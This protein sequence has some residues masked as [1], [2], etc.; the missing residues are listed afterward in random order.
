M[1]T[2]SELFDLKSN[3]TLKNK[4]AVACI[5]ASE[6]IRTESAGTTNHA[7]RLA[8]AKAV[9]ANP[10]V[11]SERMMWA[12]LAQNSAATVSQITNATDATIQTAVNNAV[13]VF[14]V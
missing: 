1:A 3:D 6:A 7:E 14:A 8:W 11:E 5:I 9:F 2:Y 13:N 10:A 4:I 12:V